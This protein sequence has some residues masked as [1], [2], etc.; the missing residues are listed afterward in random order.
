L[1]PHQLEAKDDDVQFLEIAF[2]N[3]DEED[4][5]RIKDKYGRA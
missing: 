4:I 1:Q 3:F 2:G 5:V